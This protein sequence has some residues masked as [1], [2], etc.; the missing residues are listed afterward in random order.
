MEDE[1][2]KGDDFESE[3][4][5]MAKINEGFA[6]ITGG[7]RVRVFRWTVDR[8]GRAT[9]GAHPLP[10]DT[11]SV[12]GRVLDSTASVAAGVAA[13]ARKIADY[14]ELG[15]LYSAAAPSTDM[16]KALVAAAWYQVSQG[17]TEVDAQ[18]I[19]TSLK[20]LGYPVGNITRALDVLRDS[21]PAQIMQLKKMGSS[22]QARKKFRVTME[23]L[24]AVERLLNEQPTTAT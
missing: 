5:A 24:K 8:F 16:E 19:N 11:Q 22:R 20:G 7:T 12:G 23:G 17:Q 6:L 9:V 3:I 13:A 14:P 2:I 15:E 18:A 4:A 21:R 1:T 10:G